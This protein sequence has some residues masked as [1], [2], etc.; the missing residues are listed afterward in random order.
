VNAQELFQAAALD[1]AIS[2]LNAEVRENPTDAARRTFLFEL[3]CFAGGFDRA[4]RQLDVL[5]D[6][7]REAQMGALHYRSA[8]HAERKRSAMFAD[9]S[10]PT[11]AQPRLVSGTANGRAFSSIADADSRIGGRLELFVAGEYMWLPFE[12]VS[13]VRIGPPQRLRDLLWIPAHV[14]P[15]PHLVGVELGE[16]L[17]PALTPLAWS[18]PDSLVRLG[19]ITDWKL[20][21][22]VEAPVG[23]KILL[24]DGEELPILELREL[25]IATQ[26]VA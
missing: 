9:R 11:G 15:A 6:G 24:I 23:Q 25:D 13:S 18:H 19:R 20:D 22:D 8:L 3:L 1:D 7:G 16:V 12:H 26:P 10:F 14:T 2:S 4:E 17:M 21:G 5:G